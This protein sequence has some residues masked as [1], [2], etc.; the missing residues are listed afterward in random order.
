MD[1]ERQLATPAAESTRLCSIQES[2]ANAFSA[3]L[4]ND[5]QVVDVEQGA[6]LERGKPKE[7]HGNANGSPIG[8]RKEHQGGGMFP[9]CWNKPLPDVGAERPSATHRI[10]RVGVEHI[11]DPRAVYGIGEVGLVDFKLH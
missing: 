11:D 3:A 4:R 6:S 10:S 5:R 8:A 9:Q 2:A 7:T 1:F